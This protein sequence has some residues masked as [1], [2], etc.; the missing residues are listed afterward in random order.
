[1]PKFK[2]VQGL[3]DRLNLVVRENLDG[4]LVVRAFSTQKFEEKDLTKQIV[5]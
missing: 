2:M 1:M 3:I 5:I 4:M